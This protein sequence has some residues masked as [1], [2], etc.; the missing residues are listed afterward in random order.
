MPQEGCVRTNGETAR[1]P[2]AGGQGDGGLSQRQG[3][4]PWAPPRPPQGTVLVNRCIHL[5]EQPLEAFR[6]DC[7]EWFGPFGTSRHLSVVAI[8]PPCHPEPTLTSTPSMQCPVWVSQ[9]QG[10]VTCPGRRG[11]S[12]RAPVRSAP[13]RSTHRSAP[14]C[15]PC[16]PWDREGLLPPTF[17]KS[18]PCSELRDGGRPGCGTGW[19]ADPG[20]R[21]QASWRQVLLL[22]CLCWR[23]LIVVRR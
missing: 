7:P 22:P 6:D 8:T 16:R 4:C 3:C 9:G 21:S 15:G 14:H 19:A 18:S 5:R 11:P 13:S 10:E 12:P 1:L 20:S 2:H 23:L 17:H